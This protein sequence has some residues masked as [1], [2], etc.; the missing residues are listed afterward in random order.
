MLPNSLRAKFHAKAQRR[1]VYCH[2]LDCWYELRTVIF[3]FYKMVF[4][5]F[6]LNSLAL[7]GF[8]FFVFPSFIFSLELF[9]SISGLAF[10]NWFVFCLKPVDLK[11]WILRR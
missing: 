7:W 8:L 4:L 6:L 11:H 1:K 3:I 2:Y 10:F 5:N 9:T